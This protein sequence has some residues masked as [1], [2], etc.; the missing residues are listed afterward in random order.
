[1]QLRAL[2]LTELVRR[3]STYDGENRQ[4]KFQVPFQINI[5]FNLTMY[6]WL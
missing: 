1:M 6:L 3:C 5:N 4:V 2:L